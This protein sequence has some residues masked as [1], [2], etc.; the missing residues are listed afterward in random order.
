MPFWTQALTALLRFGQS[1]GTQGFSCGVDWSGLDW[2][3]LM[4]CWRVSK[5]RNNMLMLLYNVPL[6]FP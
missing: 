4:L 2:I 6:N 3:G 5:L 1:I